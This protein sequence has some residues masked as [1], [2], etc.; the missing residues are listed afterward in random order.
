V[1]TPKRPLL[2]YI[3]VILGALISVAAAALAYGVYRFVSGR[4]RPNPSGDG[5]SESI[6]NEVKRGNDEAIKRLQDAMD[7][8]R[9]AGARS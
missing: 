7:T 6:T 5:G 3:R 4:I 2:S 9:K 1:A 8:L